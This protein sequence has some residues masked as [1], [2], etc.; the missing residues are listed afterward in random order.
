MSEK[1]S[2]SVF[3]PTRADLAGGTIDLWPVYNFFESGKT[4]NVAL[5]LKAKIHFS[6][7]SASTTEVV[8]HGMNS[9]VARFS[10]KVTS[11]A[12]KKM[13]SSCQFPAHIVSSFFKTYEGLKNLH[14]EVKVESEAPPRS[15]LGGSSTI[16]VAMA[17]GLGKVYE[18]F[19]GEKWRWEILE[20][21]KDVEAGFLRVPTGTQDYL[22]S[23]FG[24]LNCFESRYGGITQTSYTPKVF[25]EL[26]ER[27][28][29]LYSGEM[30]H[31][32]LSN[33]EVYKCAVEGKKSVLEG[34]E[35]IR[36]IADQIDKVFKSTSVSWKEIGNLI[37]DEWKV[38]RETFQVRTPKL[39]EIVDFISKQPVLGVK[40]CGAAQG[41]CLLTL[42]ESNHRKA[43][44]EACTKH[45][46]QILKTSPYAS[47]VHVK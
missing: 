45:G 47:G 35:K 13:P 2:F 33:W 5:D 21:S 22:A 4:I 14:L 9:E 37:S 34:F 39:D 44:E 20:W 40:V 36:A 23:L 7:S 8:V 30:H 25:T 19:T 11:D 46:I 15:G 3:A 27:A 16:C 38:R 28:L 17:K 31:S 10:G 12:I 43:L 6:F 1:E 41:G 29:V 26:S 18:K 32:G 24:G 42:V